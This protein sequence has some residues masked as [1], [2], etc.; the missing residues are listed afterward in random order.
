V[1]PALV[2]RVQPAPVSLFTAE[3]GPGVAEKLENDQ[4]HSPS[5]P[6][7]IPRVIHA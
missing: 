2:A 7:N 5:E 6:D 3:Y 4:P 1:R